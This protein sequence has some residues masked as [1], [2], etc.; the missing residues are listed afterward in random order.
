MSPGNDFTIQNLKEV[1][2]SAE[3]LDHL[4]SMSGSYVALFNRQ[5]RKYRELEL[6]K[7]EL[8]ESEIRQLILDEYTF[9][10]RPIFVIDSKL[11]IC[12]N[13]ESIGN[14]RRVLEQG[15]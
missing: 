6:F 15:K 1:A 2:I 10:K 4:A 5:A 12:K 14:L 7:R 9:L 11:F 8:S 3:Q 13:K